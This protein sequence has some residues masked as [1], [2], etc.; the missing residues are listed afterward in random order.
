MGN[1]ALCGLSTS[2]THCVC[3]CHTCQY[4]PHVLQEQLVLRTAVLSDML[5]VTYC[6]C[7]ANWKGIHRCSSS[8]LVSICHREKAQTWHVCSFQS[9]RECSGQLSWD[10]VSVTMSLSYPSSGAYLYLLNLGYNMSKDLRFRLDSDSFTHTQTH[11]YII[12]LCIYI[13]VYIGTHTYIC[14]YVHTYRCIYIYIYRERERERETESFFFISHLLGMFPVLK[15][16]EAEFPVGGLSLK[17]K[18]Y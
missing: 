11:T 2:L 10:M 14:I 1:P 8:F 18:L 3:E 7:F 6:Q 16:L 5:M 17:L 9:M 4:H 13:Y 15:L 12:C